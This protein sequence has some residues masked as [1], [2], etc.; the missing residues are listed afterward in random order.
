MR[1]YPGRC[2]PTGREKRSTRARS[3]R[4]VPAARAGKESKKREKGRGEKLR[5]RL[6]H[7]GA[8]KNAS[9]LAGGP[10]FGG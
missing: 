2:R 5:G 8:E 10:R 7:S 4:D 9:L 1:R 3:E 6:V